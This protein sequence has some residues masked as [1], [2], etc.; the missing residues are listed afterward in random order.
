MIAR[1]FGSALL[2][3]LGL[4]GAAACAAAPASE[5][6]SG[7][8]AIVIQNPVLTVN[9]SAGTIDPPKADAVLV[10]PHVPLRNGEIV[11]KKRWVWLP[12]G[13]K[14]TKNTSG[15]LDVPVGTTLWKEFYVKSGGS[16]VL[17]ERRQLQKTKDTGSLRD[18]EF[19]TAHKG[20]RGEEASI[21]GVVTDMNDLTGFALD[22]SK[23]APVNTFGYETTIRVGGEVQYVFPG[24]RLCTTCHSGISTMYPGTSS[25]MAYSLNTAS[26]KKESRDALVAKGFIDEDTVRALGEAAPAFDEMTPTRKLLAE[27][28]ANCMTCHSESTSSYANLTAFKLDPKRDYASGEL[29][30]ALQALSIENTPLLEN[31]PLHLEG[32]RSFM[33][34]PAGGVPTLTGG[35]V[36]PERAGV[37][38]TFEA[39]KASA[40]L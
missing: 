13:T 8:S 16:T 10:S 37:L 35:R 29:A 9:Q 26:L 19:K 2:L 11:S 39:W 18:W 30:Q 5:E 15:G 1:R 3:A 25:V 33:P 23:P 17:I 27:F 22:P 32:K 28:R 36:D 12:P 6:E 31:I 21:G 38:R 34:P 20:I 24:Q 4:I 14:L 7:E 40:G